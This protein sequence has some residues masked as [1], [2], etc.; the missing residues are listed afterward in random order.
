MEEY[1]IGYVI[2]ALDER[3]QRAVE[4]H[5]A[6]HPEARQKLALL[7]QALAPLAADAE[8]PAPP[9]G[10]VERTLAKVAEHIC[11]GG[12]R[13]DALPLAPPVSPAAHS[14]GRSWWRRPDILVA[15]C[16]LVTVVGV[17]LVVLGR[18]RGPSSTAMLAECQNNLRQFYVALQKY[19]A[20]HGEFPD[21]AKEAPRDV[22]G[23]VVPILTDAGILS[24]V[25]SIRCPGLGAPL[26]CHLTVAALRTMSED[27][28]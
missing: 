21:I 15:A 20:Q 26:S 18:M 8:A 14:S 22:A 2:G 3:T 12:H 16:L 23:V 28:F 13:P 25:A 7:K 5:L 10:L 1:L 19:H 9:P 6:Q 27:E 24:P 11:A 17:G 4:A